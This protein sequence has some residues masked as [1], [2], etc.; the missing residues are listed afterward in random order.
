MIMIQTIFG[1]FAGL[2]KIIFY[3]LSGAL[4]A[5]GILAANTFISFLGHVNSLIDVIVKYAAII[6]LIALAVT[7]LNA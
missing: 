6:A 7:L 4:I 5:Y 1:S 3:V 2:V